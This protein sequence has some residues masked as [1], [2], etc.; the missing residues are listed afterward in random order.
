[1]KP[2]IPFNPFKDHSYS[3][4]KNPY[5]MS[6]EELELL[7]YSR[8]LELR[9]KLDK[10]HKRVNYTK[11]ILEVLK[12]LG[13]TEKLEKLYRDIVSNTQPKSNSEQQP[14]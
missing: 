6:L 13:V 10:L 5:D 9:I 14:Q 8:R 11:T 2:E 12:G 3:S 1:M 4:G 7:L